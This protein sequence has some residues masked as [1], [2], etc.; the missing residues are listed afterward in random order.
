MLEK[1]LLAGTLE[2]IN[3]LQFPCLA[4]PKIDGIRAI[5][6]N[7]SVV[8]RTLKP[9][10]NDCMRLLLAELLPDG[11]DG[12]IQAG[13]TF[14]DC[15][16]EVMTAHSLEAYKKPFTFYWFDMYDAAKSYT[17]RVEAMKAHI[18]SHPDVLRHPQ[19][20]IVPLFP[21]VM[22]N[23]KDVLAYQDEALRAGHEG[24]MLRSPGGKY[25]QGRST[26]REGILLKLK[27]FKDAEAAVVGI[28]ESKRKN[29][30]GSL[31]VM[32]KDGVRF[33]VGTGFTAEMR[34]DLW[35]RRD[36]LV[37]LMVKFKY[38]EIG[39]KDAPRFPVF[40]GFRHEDD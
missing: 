15:T 1:V 40:V 13:D 20:H 18:N 7:S 36:T 12:E 21:I 16:S 8:S 37:G 32:S 6:R 26:I 2:N 31:N 35:A 33:G 34:K 30:L 28:T 10:R 38:F 9:I 25:K 39:T 22:N 5:I 17:E 24:V 29:E 4:T 19:A 23:E 11:S 3:D 14:Q 27:K